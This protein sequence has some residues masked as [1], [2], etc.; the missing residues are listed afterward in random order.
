MADAVIV[1]GNGKAY[2]LEQVEVKHID[3]A[4]Q[5][6]STDDDWFDPKPY[7]IL[8]PSRFE[9]TVKVGYVPAPNLYLDLIKGWHGQATV[10]MW[11]N[12]RKAE[13]D[14]VIT[15]WGED[16]MTL[17]LIGE[18]RFAGLENELS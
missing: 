8:I 4:Q 17:K 1:L 16:N 12:G 7:K 11:V 9:Q 2:R 3:Y 14:V 13:Q 5:S 6:K 15:Q 18:P 10:S